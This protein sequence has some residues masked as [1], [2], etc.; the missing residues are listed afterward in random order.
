M[1]VHRQELV[2]CKKRVE[3]FLYNPLPVHYNFFFISSHLVLSFFFKV[4]RKTNVCTFDVSFLQYNC[5]KLRSHINF[6][7]K[8]RCSFTKVRPAC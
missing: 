2:S 1:G 3:M 7:C 6:Y 5:F 4:E 8:S